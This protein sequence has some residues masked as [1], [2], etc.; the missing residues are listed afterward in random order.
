MTAI[1]ML[2]VKIPKQEKEP[3][4]SLKKL[5]LFHW[6]NQFTLKIKKEMRK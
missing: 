5:R 2:Q 4:R 1:Q 6:R 3:E